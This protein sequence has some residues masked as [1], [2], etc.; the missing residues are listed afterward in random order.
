MESLLKQVEE[1][2]ITLVDDRID[3]RIEETITNLIDEKI[4]V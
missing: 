1:W 2:L 3:G 4:H